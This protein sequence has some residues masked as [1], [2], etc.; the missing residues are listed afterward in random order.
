MRRR[1]GKLALL[2]AMMLPDG[3][4]CAWAPPFP[5]DGME[6]VFA[7]EGEINGVTAQFAVWAAGGVA[8]TLATSIEMAGWSAAAVP[9]RLLAVPAGAVRLRAFRLGARWLILAV[10]DG[11]G[12]V[13]AAAWFD[14]R[15]QWAGPAG[16]DAPGREPAGWPRL[17]A[18]HRLLHLRGVGFEAACYRTAAGAEEVV[19]EA[20][21]RLPAAGW[22]VTRTDPASLAAWRPGA[23]DVA[24]RALAQPDG[25]LFL[26]LATRS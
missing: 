14:R 21:R 22:R 10:P 23:P 2:M 26:V 25:A 16:G 15:P 1:L 6:P 20:G 9:G 13:A 7:G 18:A 17:A 8:M 12:Q 11:A 19:A 5:A 4:R 24:L 3:A